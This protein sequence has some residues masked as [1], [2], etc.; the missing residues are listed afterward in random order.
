M[1][2]PYRLAFGSCS[3]PAL[4]QPLWPIISSRKNSA[5]IWGGDAIY[6]DRNAGSN[7]TAVGLH[8]ADGGWMVTFPPPSIHV[9][10]T[11]DVIRRWY[12]KQ[13]EVE[14]YRKFLEGFDVNV[15]DIDGMGTT[16]MIRSKP[17]IFGTI[18]DHDY[19]Q[20]NGDFTYQFKK[21]SNLAFID[22]MYGDIAKDRECALQEADE[23]DSCRS[24]ENEDNSSS[25]ERK[26][27]SK[28]SDP[29]H[30]R[31][32]DGKGVYGVQL[33]DFSRKINVDDG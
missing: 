7:W 15:S 10:A 1:P 28:L 22:F 25:H 21:E 4:P 9:E 18:D 19:G 12:V 24:T 23:K 33:F 32:L 8:R 11:P 27:R 14:G 3:H 16:G 13:L 2:Q 5:F 20:N 6:A 30:Q 29:M 31:S 26:G 17:I